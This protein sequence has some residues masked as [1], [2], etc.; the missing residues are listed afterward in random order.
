MANRFTNK[1]VAFSHFLQKAKEIWG[2]EYDYSKFNYTKALEKGIIICKKHGEFLKSPNKHTRKGDSQ[3]CPQCTNERMSESMKTLTHSFISRSNEKH[4][5]RYTYNIQSEKIAMKDKVSSICAE[6]G[7]FRQVADLHM[8]GEGCPK[9]NGG[10]RKSREDFLQ[11]L[12][13]SQLNTY[14]YSKVHNFKRQ[15]EKVTILCKL[16]GN[17]F[18]QSIDNHLQGKGCNYCRKTRGWSKTQW[19]DWCNK[20]NYE[21]VSVYIIKLTGNDEDFYKFGISNNIKNRF[22]S[23]NRLPYNYEVVE[24]VETNNFAFSY[25]L[26]NKIRASVREFSYKPKLQFSGFTEC[27]TKD[28]FNVAIQTLYKAKQ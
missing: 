2:E 26:E 1:E 6:H 16:C 12:T 24:I 18:K 27:F 9:C 4:N 17:E 10:V 8:R 21:S 5:F 13:S 15:K 23:A 20:L 19:V 7:E 25:D 28:G 14:D 22:G 11:R 3:G